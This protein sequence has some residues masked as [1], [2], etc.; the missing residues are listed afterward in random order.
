MPPATNGSRMASAM[1]Q[2][3]KA[4]PIG[5]TASRTARPTMKLP[6]QNSDVSVSSRYGEAY[7]GAARPSAGS[8][9][10]RFIAVR[11]NRPSG[12]LGQWLA[13]A[14]LARHTRH[15]TPNGD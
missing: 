15:S 11:R 13:S 7:Q 6:A 9:R 5:G 12:G 4:S 10:P 14:L 3:Q 2:R 8:P 1:T